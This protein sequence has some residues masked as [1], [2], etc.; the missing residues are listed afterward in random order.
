MMFDTTQAVPALNDGGAAV[1]TQL[2]AS[3]MVV[4]ILQQ[5]KK[6][7]T[8]PWVSVETDKLNRWLAVLGAALA[9][10]GIHY[11]FDHTAGVLTI[12]G[13]TLTG[14]LTGTWHWFQSYVV[15]EALYRATVYKSPQVE[16]Q[17]GGSK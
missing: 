10:I 15:Q 12:T 14:I 6:A 1:L 2:T 17:A 3:A 13:L 7:K 16:N 4:W 11:T 9:S 8:I 5:L